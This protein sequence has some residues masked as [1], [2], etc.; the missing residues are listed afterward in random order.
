MDAMLAEVDGQSS[1]DRRWATSAL[2]AAATAERR[3]LGRARA[4]VAG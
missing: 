2:E 1:L 4:L 3:L